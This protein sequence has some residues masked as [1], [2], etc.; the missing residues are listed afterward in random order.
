M[1]SESVKLGWGDFA[2]C[3]VM[4]G[5]FFVLLAWPIVSYHAELKWKID[6]LQQRIHELEGTR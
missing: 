4:I 2:G 6:R 1:S 3:L 5:I